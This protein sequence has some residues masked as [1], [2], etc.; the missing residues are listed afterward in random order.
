MP[1]HTAKK[2]SPKKTDGPM[3]S[4]TRISSKSPAKSKK[5]TPQKRK[6]NAGYD[7]FAADDDEES[8]KEE[9]QKLEEPNTRIVGIDLGMWGHGK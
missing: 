5:T 2:R 4:G 7:G 8:V 9:P 1:P 6:V 3:L